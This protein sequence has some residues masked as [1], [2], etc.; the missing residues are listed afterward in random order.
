[1]KNAI[2]E[3][4]NEATRDQLLD[5][6]HLLALSLVHHRTKFGVIPLQYSLAQLGLPP[7]K[8]ATTALLDKER[9]VLEETYKLVR[10]SHRKARQQSAATALS[11]NEKQVLEEVFKLVK[12]S[13]G[14]TLSSRHSKAP[15]CQSEVPSGTDSSER[16]NQPRI[17]VLTQIRLLWHEESIPIEATLENISWG[18]AAF[19]LAQQHRRSAGKD[20][21]VIIPSEQRGLTMVDAEIIRTR[22]LPY[23]QRIAVRFSNVT[24]RG[25]EA[26]ENLLEAFIKSGDTEG[27]REYARLT[28]RLEMQFGDSEELQ[29]ALKDISTGGLGVTVP[30]PLELNRSFPVVISTTDDKLSFK[31]RAH[32]VRQRILVVGDKEVYHVGLKFEHPPE[33]LRDRTNELIREMALSQNRHATNIG[34]KQSDDRFITTKL[35]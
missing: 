6:V 8:S 19:R 3:I 22:D 24:T 26:L 25:E 23:G 1:M 18:G 20:V 12:S 5:C 2:D 13:R 15:S 31:L 27:R 33:E 10:S 9:Q 21:K 29:V 30:Q 4:V 11:D 35:T 14:K 32:A 16:R 34:R 17:N 7:D 28:Y